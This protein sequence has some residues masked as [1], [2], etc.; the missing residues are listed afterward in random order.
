L[1]DFGAANPL[2]AG[3]WLPHTEMLHIV[4]RYRRPDLGHLKI[5]VTLEDP[6]TFTKPVERHVTWLHTPSEEL[7]EGICGE[8][9]KFLKYPDVK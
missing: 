7:L 9:N 2:L 6:A 4:S 3:T 8:N 1:R 5:D